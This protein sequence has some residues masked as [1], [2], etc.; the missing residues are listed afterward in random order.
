MYFFRNEVDC[1]IFCKGHYLCTWFSYAPDHNFCQ[2]IGINTT[3]G[4]YPY[5]VAGSKWVTGQ[6]VCPLPEC[7]LKGHVQGKLLDTK[8]GNFVQFYH[9]R[10]ILLWAIMG[11]APFDLHFFFNLKIIKSENLVIT[12][13]LEK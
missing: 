4:C 6:N 2:L 3:S 8:P 12:S 1:L 7:W 9:Y 13:T 11:N 5:A 10:K